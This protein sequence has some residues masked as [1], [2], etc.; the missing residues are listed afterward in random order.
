[1]KFKVCDYCGAHLDNGET[2][3]CRENDDGKNSPDT[4]SEERTN[5]N[6]GN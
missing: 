5:D 3:D 1:M 6:D 4:K 2:C